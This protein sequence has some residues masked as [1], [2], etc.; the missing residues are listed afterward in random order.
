MGMSMHRKNTFLLKWDPDDPF[1]VRLARLLN[2]HSSCLW[3][4]MLYTHVASLATL[5][6]PRNNYRFRV[7]STDLPKAAS[8]RS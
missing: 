8:D 2:K 7:L 1:I 4:K 3:N 5:M 6:K